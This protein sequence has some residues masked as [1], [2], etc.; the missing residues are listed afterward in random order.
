VTQDF[1]LDRIDVASYDSSA[2]SA[3]MALSGFTSVGVASIVY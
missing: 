3:D 1:G 2:Y